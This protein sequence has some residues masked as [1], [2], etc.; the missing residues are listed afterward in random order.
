LSAET[1]SHGRAIAYEV[2]LEAGDVV[3]GKIGVGS[4]FVDNHGDHHHRNPL[5]QPPTPGGTEFVDT[6]TGS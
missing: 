5:P 2:K 6:M 4:L 3:S 1:V